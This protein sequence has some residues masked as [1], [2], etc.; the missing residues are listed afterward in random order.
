MI[1]SAWLI[2]SSNRRRRDAEDSE[3]C[4]HHIF[5]DRPTD[6]LQDD[7]TAKLNPFSQA[8]VNVKHLECPL[9]R[10][11]VYT[12][13]LVSLRLLCLTYA[14]GQAVS[15]GTN[16][17]GALVQLST[18][19]ASGA[20]VHDVTLSGNA[21]WYA[22]SLVDTGTVTL[23][24]SSNGASQMQLELSSSGSRTE[25]QTGT[26]MSTTC[27]W[28]GDDNKPHVV[29][30]QNCWK[31][32]LWF[33]PAFS[34][35]PSLTP[36]YVGLVDLG[37]GTVGPSSTIYRHLQCQV[38]FSGLPDSLASAVAQQSTTDIGLDTV[39]LLPAIVTYSLLPDS[40]AITPVQVSIEYANYQIVNGA[41]IP[42]LVRRFV[43]GALQLEL[44]VSSAQIN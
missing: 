9:S 44:Q 40:G 19:F 41:K 11:R 42:F 33:L 17:H 43:N 20:I 26:G 8:R 2:R 32:T 7:V 14:H 15:S 5:L 18:A 37:T 4:D 3:N 27:Q 1:A 31:P 23:T 13:L 25:S 29:D 21:T 30:S 12:L 35:Q 24:A 34:L 16:A 28:V 10:K 39:T 6:V 22:G 38:T 36:N